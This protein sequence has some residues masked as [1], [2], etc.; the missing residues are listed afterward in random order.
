MYAS[1]SQDS[2]LEAASSALVVQN[3]DPSKSREHSKSAN[4]PHTYTSIL[5]QLSD[6][7][8]QI[9]VVEMRCPSRL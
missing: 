2:R 3:T 8:P 7:S 1:C 6:H 5:R 9:A 4:G